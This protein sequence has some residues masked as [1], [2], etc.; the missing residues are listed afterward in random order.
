MNIALLECCYSEVNFVAAESLRTVEC[1][2]GEKG[3]PP[4][5]YG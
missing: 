3:G 4:F 1:N 5:F 2:G